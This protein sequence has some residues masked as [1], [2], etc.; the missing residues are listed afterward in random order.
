MY[1]PGQALFF[2]RSGLIVSVPVTT[3][4]P[5][6]PFLYTIHQEAHHIPKHVFEDSFS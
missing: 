4:I 3:K 6:S 5:P 1:D 2:R